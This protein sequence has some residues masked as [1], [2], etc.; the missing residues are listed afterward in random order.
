MPL[1]PEQSPANDEPG[2]PSDEQAPD[3]A[4]T[5]E[6]TPEA[7]QSTGRRSPADRLAAVYRQWRAPG[8]PSATSIALVRTTDGDPD[9][10]P[11]L[12][13]LGVG[14]PVVDDAWAAWESAQLTS[15]ATP[16]GRALRPLVAL[17]PH[18]G[19]WTAA[20]WVAG[21]CLLEPVDHDD[22]A[23]ALSAAAARLELVA[24]R[25]LRDWVDEPDAEDELE[26]G[27]PEAEA[28]DA[29]LARDPEPTAAPDAP[30]DGADGEAR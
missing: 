12:E 3:A 9:G 28:A 7:G 19:R 2:Q 20:R 25:R 6:A 27:S 10:L 21:V 1:D 18:G 8:R 23:H 14:G 13:L 4:P 22:P 11:F 24:A 15:D 26:D 29:D 16:L 17:V 30:A 5:P